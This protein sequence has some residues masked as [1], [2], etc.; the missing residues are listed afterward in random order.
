MPAQDRVHSLDAVRAFALLLGVAFHASMSF[1]PGMLPG[2][3]VTVE[4]APSVMLGQLFFVSH[5]FRMALFFVMAGFFARMLYMR[6]G[7]R[8]FWAN[9]LKRIAVPLI[10]GWC[11][12]FPL[13]LVVQVWGLSQL[14][15]GHL[16][17]AMAKPRLPPGFFPFLHFWFL[18]AL[19]L[20]YPLTLGLRR[21]ILWI[22][23]R[24]VLCAALDRAAPALFATPA[25]V[26]LAPALLG[27]PLGL[28]LF[29]RENWIYWGGIPAQEMTYI[30][31]LTGIVGFGTAVVAGWLLHRNRDLLQSLERRWVAHLVIALAATAYC[32]S[33]AG[34]KFVILP[35]PQNLA[36]AFF[37][38][39]FVVASWS[40]VFAI[41][42]AAVRYWS[43]QSR[44]RRYIADSSYWIYIAHLPV[45][46]ALDVLV[47]GWPVHWSVKYGFVLAVSFGLLFTSYHFLVRPTFLGEWLN[48]RKNPRRQPSER[49]SSPGATIPDGDVTTVA[50][51]ES[52]T[53]RYDK[54]LALDGMSL[55]LARSELV[56]LLG[57]N[58]A[59]KTSAIGLWLGL[60]EP[61]EGRVTLLGGSPLDVERRRGI[62][63]MMQ[64]VTLAP[65][66]RVRELI[67][68]TASYYPDPMSVEEA[69]AVAQI[70]GLALR[71]YDKLSGGQKR[72]VQFALAICGR[73]SVLFLDEPT[74]GLD[75][76]A[77]ENL[78]DA[79]RKLRQS[80]CSIL[81]TT[82]YLEEAE[83]L[84]DRVVV[85]ARG[86]V[87]ASGTVDE[88]RALVSRRLIRC[89]SM[90][91]VQDLSSWPGVISANHAVGR[92]V[93]TVSDAEGVLR[94]LLASDLNVTHIEVQQAGLAEAFVELTKSTQ[95]E[96][97]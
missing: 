96:A 84:A 7:P 12:V 17:A 72:Q 48:G 2:L 14:F 57:P 33:V 26:L 78:W 5:I 38:A 10:V 63:V 65:G 46:A 86:R 35:A 54:V 91:S 23:R 74:V 20:L 21:A 53:R 18:Y 8:G 9:R 75:I 69:M 15:G 41:I 82:H 43:H 81:L 71:V 1:V 32:S 24:G 64:D 80:G 92:L 19:L 90:L 83:A 16:P 36:K 73:P 66:M 49:A 45:V 88:I 95:Q 94:R 61:Q 27:A 13:F 44:I 50:S 87:I 67:T 47:H 31:Q 51:L 79:I 97:A 76:A 4:T 29:L 58:G 42:G 89:K 59:G 39:S 11:V 93:L 85:L 77:R 28:T 6:S 40:W 60:A 3:W 34:T 25:A 70:T 22:D 37:A 68:Q 52:V 62:G 30:P 55:S 56:A